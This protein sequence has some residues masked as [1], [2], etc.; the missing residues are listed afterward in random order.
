MLLVFACLES[1]VRRKV[2]A[3]RTF[4]SDAKCAL[5]GHLCPTKSVRWADVCVRR[6]VCGVRTFVSDIKCVMVKRFVEDMK[7]D[8]VYDAK[9]HSKS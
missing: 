6:K 1:C 7:V 3:G 2:C 5:G 4:V 8:K 9:K